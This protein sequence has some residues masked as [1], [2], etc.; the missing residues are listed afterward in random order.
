L[1]FCEKEKPPNPHYS[2]AFRLF[3]LYKKIHQ[4]AKFL[5]KNKTH[6]H[7][8][9]QTSVWASSTSYPLK[10][11]LEEPINPLHKVCSKQTKSEW[12]D[13]QISDCGRAELV[14][15]NLER[16]PKRIFRNQREG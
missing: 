12:L 1:K 2:I 8:H 14:A 16:S 5:L 7:T 15:D 4:D 10:Q 6:T 11:G 3:F 9:K 13:S